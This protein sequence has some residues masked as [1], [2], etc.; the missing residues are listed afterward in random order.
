M[1]VSFDRVEMIAGAL[2][3]SKYPGPL[4][5]VMR[6]IARQA[7]EDT[8]MSHDCEYTNWQQVADYARRLLGK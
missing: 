1:E 3:Y 2:M 4:K 7:G 6:R 5:W 8:D